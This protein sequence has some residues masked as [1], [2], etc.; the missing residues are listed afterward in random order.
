[1][2]MTMK[3]KKFEDDAVVKSIRKAIRLEVEKEYKKR[4]IELTRFVLTKL[5]T[6]CRIEITPTRGEDNVLYAKKN[7]NEK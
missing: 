6:D 3:I 7:K 1:M 5:L 2:T 4:D